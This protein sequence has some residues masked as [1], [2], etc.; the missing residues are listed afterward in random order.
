ML[1]ANLREFH[2]EAC[3]VLAKNQDNEAFSE[4]GTI[5][6]TGENK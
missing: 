6:T 4:F 2:L 5:E 1:V 3:A